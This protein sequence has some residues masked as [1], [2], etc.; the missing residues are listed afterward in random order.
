MNTSIHSRS[1]A[2]LVLVCALGTQ[3]DRSLPRDHG[4]TVTPQRAGIETCYAVSKTSQSL[5]TGFELNQGQTDARVRFV[6]RGAGY[7][8][9][10]TPSEAVLA[11]NPTVSFD[12]D[13]KRRHAGPRELQEPAPSD[14]PPV[15]FRMELPG[16]SREAEMEG[17]EELPTKSN[18]FIGNDPRKWRTG[19]PVF[20]KVR[21]QG[22]Y[23]GV[24]LVFY[25]NP[26]QLEFDFI[27]SPGADPSAISLAFKGAEA[28]AVDTEGDLVLGGSGARVRLRRPLIYQLDGSKRQEIDGGYIVENGN[29]VAFRVKHGYDRE[30]PLIIDPVLVYSTYL[31]GSG[32]DNGSGIA[33]DQ[34]GN[35]YVIGTTASLDFPVG[36][37]PRPPRRGYSDA[38]V[39]KLNAA[40]SSIVYSAFIGGGSIDVGNDVAVDASGNVYVTGRTDSLDF[41]AVKPLQQFKGGM[42]A[43][44][45]KLDPAGSKLIYSTCLG[46]SG[47]DIAYKIA[48]D[49]SGNAYVTGETSSPDFPVF[50]AVQPVIGSTTGNPAGGG[51]FSDAFVTRLSAAGSAA[52]YS[53]YLGGDFH[54]IGN[55]IAVDPS[56]A[57]YVTGQTESTDFPVVNA[58]Q[59]R[60][61]GGQCDAF[62]VK[63]NPGGGVLGYSTYLGGT[64]DDAGRS[65]AVEPSGRTTVTG[66]TKSR[67][68]P[69]LNAIQATYPSEPQSWPGL[70]SMAFVTRLNPAGSGLVYSTYL[71]GSNGESGTGIAVDR[72]GNA[73]VTGLTGS[74]DFPVVNA[75]Q[76]SPGE[77]PLFKSTDGAA[78]WYPSANGISI[79]RLYGAGFGVRAL[80][81]DPNVPAT[82]YAGT[83]FG[84]YKTSNGGRSW[85][86]SN[87][88]IPAELQ[89]TFV[90]VSPTSP[91]TL[92][93]IP[94]ARAFEYA[95]KVGVFRSTNGGG[96]WAASNRGFPTYETGAIATEIL[97]IA[98]DP[99]NPTTVYAATWVGVY[100]STDGGGKW[101][102]SNTGLTDEVRKIVID[103]VNPATLYATPNGNGVCKSSDGGKTWASTPTRFPSGNT[104][105]ALVTSPGPPSILYVVA[106]AAGVLKTADGGVTWAQVG[107][108]QEAVT[109]F[110]VDPV[111]PA[112]LYAVTY[113]GLRKSTDGG[114]TWSGP[115]P[116]VPYFESMVQTLVIDPESPSTIYAGT[117]GDS[118]SDFFVSKLN[119]AGSSLLYSTF[120]GG[121]ANELFASSIAVDAEGNAYVTGS[122]SSPDFP[123][124]TPAQ[125][126]VA[127]SYDATVT[128]ISPAIETN[129]AQFANGGGFVSSLVLTNPSPTERAEGHVSFF[130]DNGQPLYLSINGGPR[131]S[132]AAF[133]IPPLGGTRLSTDGAGD[134]IAGSV[135]VSSNAPVAGV[136]EFAD[137]GLGTAGVGESA[138]LVDLM[139]PVASDTR[140]G[141][142][143]GIAISNPQPRDV[144]ISL[145]LQGHD[146]LKVAGG[147]ASE[148]LPGNGHLA[149]FA[150]Q[151]FPNARL[152]SFE[153]ILVASNLDPAARINATALQVGSGA[154]QMTTLPV[155][156]IDPVPSR[157]ELL[158]AQF[159]NG[160][161]LSSS[162][163]LTNPLAST[164]SGEVSFSDNEGNPLA[165][166]VNAQ[167]PAER[168][169][170]SIEPLGGAIFTTN[171]QG[172]MVVGSA[173]VVATKALGGVLR[174]SIPGLGI[175]GVGVSL[176][177]DS[178]IAPVRNS[179]AGDLGTGIAVMSIDSPVRLTL[180]L[181]D[182]NGE[183]VPGGEAALDLKARGHLARFV[184]ELFPGAG[185]AEFEGTL[186][187]SA[188]GGKVAAT[189]IEL[190][191]KPGQFTTLPVA[192]IK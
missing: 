23:P 191:S 119:P 19:V 47:G 177:M 80:A 28:V 78:T 190:G 69:I 162:L 29:R 170:F 61:G 123:T 149:K 79:P 71:G 58:Y 11:L 120:L 65:I 116:A 57:A 93:A 101:V 185:I 18:Y 16:A 12:R 189:A 27:V 129:F 139:T 77:N 157:S 104:I 33:V 163:F 86:P 26:G 159:G 89:V 40:G 135:R 147:S 10:L 141:L 39:T 175:A 2:A 34:A 160:S 45:A 56:G 143:T 49:S 41:P 43:F 74:V 94:G 106:G 44:V 131:G 117:T 66:W 171:G 97:D 187:V 148:R 68:F 142:Y 122:S 64:N 176:P 136:V 21:Q 144:D 73:F 35:S 158:F 91:P 38:F 81:I 152:D 184:H 51:Y 153:G 88:G 4:L 109:N 105:M 167:P 183:P 103:P 155:V 102:P 174:F 100:K 95:P 107:N 114:A 132:T 72:S 60:M 92:F 128:K 98:I 161:S 179:L 20:G 63:V 192:E 13:G 156:A 108:L 37:L 138:A 173:R 115:S 55:G 111:T 96:S 14:K 130:K 32:G 15:A 52:V 126:A 180:I 22:V 75:A 118:I 169:P 36:N 7:S 25:R 85:S 178:F 113:N 181:R 112:T 182:R 42:D 146:G 53:T 154:G 62:V 133:S 6:A 90:A 30:L 3:S 140:L 70:G 84:V 83:T 127:G 48:L 17:I 50:N 24:D 76:P 5:A 125:N 59:P 9:F 164:T 1:S 87:T 8:L 168:I 151:I 137:P 99:A 82:L 166:S 172:D 188:E 46:G 150:N 31:G 145:S 54:D 124:V 186:T 110:V 67:D 165:V 121:R 134:L